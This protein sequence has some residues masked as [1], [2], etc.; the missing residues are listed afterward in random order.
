VFS[1]VAGERDI[2]PMLDGKN[3]TPKLEFISALPGGGAAFHVVL[4][5]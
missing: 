4:P 3:G 2:A 1:S 5:R